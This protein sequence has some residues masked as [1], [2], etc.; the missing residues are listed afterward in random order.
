MVLIFCYLW[1]YIPSRFWPFYSAIFAI[2]FD[3]LS[4]QFPVFCKRVQLFANYCTT[5][6]PIK[7]SHSY[8]SLSDISPIFASKSNEFQTCFDIS[9]WKWFLEK[10]PFLV[11]PKAR[12]KKVNEYWEMLRRYPKVVIT[13]LYD[14][15]ICQFSH[16]VA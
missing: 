2:S 12:L 11:F 7:Y 9:F 10:I 16:K 1:L 6:T 5:S 3:L 15:Q 13:V 4:P 8:S 14:E